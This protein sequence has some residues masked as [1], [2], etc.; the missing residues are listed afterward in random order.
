MKPSVLI[1][2]ASGSLGRPLVEEFQS[3]QSRFGRV[4]ILSDPA[5]A[6]KFD[7]VQKNGVEVIV[8]SFL[9][10]RCYQGAVT[11]SASEIEDEW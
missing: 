5:K 10:F 11:F 7:A 8:G 3:Q 4:A 1:I 9:D 2:G 6:H